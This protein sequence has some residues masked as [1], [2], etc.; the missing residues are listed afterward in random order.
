MGRAGKAGADGEFARR[1]GRTSAAALAAALAL[2]IARTAAAQQDL[3]HKVMGSLGLQ[4]GSQGPEGIAA[5]DQLLV[6]RATDVLDRDGHALPA[7]VD[8]TAVSNMAGAVAT[9]RVAPLPLYVSASFGVPVS[10]ARVTTQSPEASLDCFGLADLFFQPMKLGVRTARADVVASYALYSPT[11]KFAPGSTGN[12]GRGYWTQQ[13][14][15][16]GTLF[17]DDRRRWSVSALASLDIN[18]RTRQVD[19]TRGTTLAVQGGVGTRVRSFLGVGLV[20]SALWQVTDDQGGALPAALRGARDCDYAAGPE[21]DVDIPVV[22]LSAVL[23]YEHDF[24]VQS[25]P[26]GQVFFVAL[27]VLAWEPGR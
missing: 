9:F 25:R 23:R 27:K 20:A 22:R 4:A 13:P 17:F 14:S 3:S 10:W 18:S 16:G 6:Y 19:L 26:L 1:A 24:L 21:L 11:G 2:G 8:T 12:V 7:G 5:V 15:L